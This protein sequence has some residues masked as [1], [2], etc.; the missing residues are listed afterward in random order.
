[1]ALYPQGSGMAQ[2]IPIAVPDFEI[3]T[4]IVLQLNLAG[5]SGPPSPKS[6]AGVFQE[7]VIPSCRVQ[8]II[9]KGAHP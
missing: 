9:N 1:M 4:V 5:D 6:V 7:R 3:I 8:F 2:E